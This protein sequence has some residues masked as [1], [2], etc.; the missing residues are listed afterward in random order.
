MAIMESLWA[1]QPLACKPPIPL[2]DDSDLQ[3]ATIKPHL[4]S[5]LQQPVQHYCPELLFFSTWSLS[6]IHHMRIMPGVER[7]C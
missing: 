1:W 3:P 5:V 7:K 6:V 4:T 2:S